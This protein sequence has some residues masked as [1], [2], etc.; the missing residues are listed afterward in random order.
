[1]LFGGEGALRRLLTNK[2]DAHLVLFD[3]INLTRPEYFLTRFFYALEHGKGRIEEGLI[4]GDCRAF[5]TLNID[6]T[7][8]PPSPK[9]VDRCFLVELAQV[10]W[11]DCRS[12]DLDN[13][14]RLPILPGLPAVAGTGMSTDERVDVVLKALQGAVEEHDLRDD[15]LP[16]R[17]VLADIRALL[18]LHHRL[19][20]E[21]TGLLRRDELVDRLL[22]SRVLVKLTG[23]LEQLQPALD[24]LDGATDG[25]EELVRTR[26]RL[27]LARQQAKLGFVSPWQ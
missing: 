24:A 11:D 7:S 5:G 8:R 6:D 22:Y 12:A 23:A 15:L 3:E 27:K 4:I 21:A 26:R 16:S 1:M 19:D 18:A 17:R 20:L 13:L 10:S 9:I 2:S 14:Q 25:M